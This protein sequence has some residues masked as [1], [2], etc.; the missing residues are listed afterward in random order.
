MPYSIVTHPGT[1]MVSVVNTA[2]GAVHSK[3]T[4]PEKARA[5]VRLLYG[6]EHGMKLRKK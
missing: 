6:I 4:T 5:Q 2:T 3:H 1:G